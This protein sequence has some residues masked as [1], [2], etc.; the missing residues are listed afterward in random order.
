[1]TDRPQ[2]AI[3]GET[4]QRRAFYPPEWIRPSRRNEIKTV[5]MTELIRASP[6]RDNLTAVGCS[7]DPLSGNFCLLGPARGGGD[8][9]RFP[10]AVGAKKKKTPLV[11]G[12]EPRFFPRLNA[13]VLVHTSSFSSSSPPGSLLSSSV[14]GGRGPG[15]PSGTVRGSAATDPSRRRSQVSA[16]VRN[17]GSGGANSRSPLL[18]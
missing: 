10:T 1:M 16:G 7:S 14:P 11:T 6:L 3:S 4:A 8:P 2:H 15:L 13:S 12:E 5:L 17:T 9:G 18:I